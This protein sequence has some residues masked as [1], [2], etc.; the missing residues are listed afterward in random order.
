M[1]RVFCPRH[2]ER[3]PS[4]VIYESHGYCFGGCGIIPLSE[5]GDVAPA[6]PVRPTDLKSEL[7]RI[8]LLPTGS[9]RGL[10]LPIDSDSFYIVW[11]EGNYYKRRKFFPGEG[12]KYLCPRGHTKPLFIAHNPKAATQVAVIEGE[13]NAMSLAT[14]NPK[15]AICSPGGVNQ[16]NKKD[17]NSL[18]F[19]KFILILDKDRAGLEAALKAREILIKRTPYVEIV[20]ME[21]DLNQLLQDG[22]LQDEAKRRGWVGM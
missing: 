17:L 4:V 11:P 10:V 7:E 5:L 6:A 20:L 22:Q 1:Q 9:V 12:P 3:T 19:N 18:H 8:R 13:I 15:F 16:F 14:L 2:Q 21:K